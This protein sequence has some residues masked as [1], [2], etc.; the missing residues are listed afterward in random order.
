MLGESDYSTVTGSSS[1]IYTPLTG[2]GYVQQGETGEGI[3]ISLV[4]NFK[5]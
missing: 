4:L 2:L 3:S 1:V 5:S